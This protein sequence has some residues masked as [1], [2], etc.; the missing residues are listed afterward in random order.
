MSAVIK[1]SA[2]QHDKP[3]VSLRN[4]NKY[5]G[6]FAAVDNI[7]LDIKDGEFLTFLGSSGSGKSTTLSMLAGFETPS[8][9]E[10]L[11]NGQSLVNVPPHKRDIGMVFQRYSLFPHLSVRDNIA[12]P[13]SIR[14]LAPAERER[15]VD[16]MLKLVQLEQFAHRRPSQ[17]SGGQ[18]QRVAIARALVYE[19]RILLMDEPLGALDKKLRE[20]LQDE[21]RQLHRRLGITIIYV[22]HDQEEAMRLSQRIAIFSHG[23][24][25]GLGSGYDLYQN[26]PNAFVASFLGNSNFLKLKAQGNAVASFEGQSLSIRLT[27]GLQTD[28]DVLLMV[29]PEKALALSVEQASQEP[30]AAGWNEV[31]AKVVEVLFLGESQTCSVV[32]SGGTSMTVKAL[33]A[34]GMPLK[35]GDPVRVRWATADACVYTEWAESDLN[36][37]AG[38]H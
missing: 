14:K 20:D 33:S 18:Q 23:K 1:D 2:Q 10:I 36:K 28:Q 38:A 9:G 16:A 32:T 13:L 31:S 3:L 5:Y 17:L 37:A 26:P 21:L 29:R 6:D 24:I 35:A 27:A 30:L 22:T 25:V 19:P 11:V 8:S 15:R 4:L 12:F 34:A 7:S